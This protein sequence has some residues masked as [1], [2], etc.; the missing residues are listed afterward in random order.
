MAVREPA[1]V[2]ICDPGYLADLKRGYN[3]QQFTFDEYIAMLEGA[4][5]AYQSGQID[6]GG[7]LKLVAT[8][9]S[10]TAQ[11]LFQRARDGVQSAAK[12]LFGA[13]VGETLG[14]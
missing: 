11:G 3:E 4:G 13:T 1:S 12:A 10:P 8:P 14:A 7:S 9:A 6:F 2:N 5:Y